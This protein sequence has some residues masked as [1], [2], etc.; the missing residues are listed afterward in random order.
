[1]LMPQVPPG[2]EVRRQVPEEVEAVAQGAAAPQPLANP[3]APSFHLAAAVSRTRAAPGGRECPR[4]PAATAPLVGVL[5]A[6]ERLVA[7]RVVAAAGP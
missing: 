6:G 3:G 2:V 7:V 4:E 5:L 1:M